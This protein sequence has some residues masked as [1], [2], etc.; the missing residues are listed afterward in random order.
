MQRP[1]DGAEL[2]ERA[3][4][5]AIDS[6]ITMNLSG[7]ARVDFFIEKETNQ[8]YVNEINTIPAFSADSM[9]ARMW[10][11]VGLEYTELLDRLIGAAF[12]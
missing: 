10:A 5:L 1:A 11:A 7:Y 4:Q 6:Y 12:D 8:L 2:A 3:K 9:F